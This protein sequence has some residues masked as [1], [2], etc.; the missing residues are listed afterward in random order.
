MDK[1][2]YRSNKDAM[3]FGV[4]G[5]L[6]EYFEIDPTIVRVIFVLMALGG[7]GIVAYII[8]ALV[9]PERK[10]T[11]PDDGYRYQEEG[12]GKKTDS[13][14]LIG[15]LLIGCGIVAYAH[16]FVPGFSYDLLW[17][18]TMIAVGAFVI[19]KKRGHGNGQQ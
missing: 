13:S 15:I 4:C 1:R 6:A 10:N 18:A 8:C 17:P 2:V 7:F 14:I 12:T 3:L 9:I 11:S 16:K 5:G 19:V